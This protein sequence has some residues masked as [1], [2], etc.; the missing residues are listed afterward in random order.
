V[1][2]IG[3]GELRSS[4]VRGAHAGPRPRRRGAMC[5][6][7]PF[8]GVGRA[9]GR[10]RIAEQPEVVMRGEDDPEELERELPGSVRVRGVLRRWRGGS[11]WRRRR[12]ARVGRRRANPAP[13]RADRRIRPKRRASG[14][15]PRDHR[16]VSP[17]RAS[18]KKSSETRQAAGLFQCGRENLLEEQG[19]RLLEVRSCKSSWNRSER[20]ARS[21]TCPGAAREPM[22]NPPNR[23][24]LRGPP[25]R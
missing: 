7:Q 19:L 15:R 10:A 9:F 22:L 16:C 24:D 21:W 18:S 2:G 11:P 5:F 6:D 25:P 14:S 3:R 23:L 20:R 12:A 13:P 17:T 1:R 4:G 8:Q